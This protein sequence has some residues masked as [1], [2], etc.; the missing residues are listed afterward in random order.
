[1]TALSSITDDVTASCAEAALTA[2]G[3]TLVTASRVHDGT[4][5]YTVVRFS[6]SF[7]AAGNRGRPSSLMS[8]NV[9]G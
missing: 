2:S 4:L 5:G 1:M 6:S 7:R 3:Y 9:T 8:W